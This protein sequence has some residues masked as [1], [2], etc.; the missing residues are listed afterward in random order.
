MS[1]I[2]L[3]CGQAH[4]VIAYCPDCE[5]KA[6]RLI[7]MSHWPLET[8]LTAVA[9]MQLEI[10]VRTHVA[11]LLPETPGCAELANLA[12]IIRAHLQHTLRAPAAKPAPVA[13]DWLG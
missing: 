4:P 10:A 3:G 7:Q 5:R 6:M 9:L 12:N 8:S 11:A 13:D 2:C 1:A